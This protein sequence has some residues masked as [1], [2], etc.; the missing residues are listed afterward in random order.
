MNVAPL[1]AF[2]MIV[3]LGVYGGAVQ[4]NSAEAQQFYDRLITPPST[5]AGNLESAYNAL[6]DGSVAAG[7]MARV[8]AMF[9]PCV[10]H[11]GPG[12]TNIPNT[13]LL[14]WA[15]VEYVSGTYSFVPRSGWQG[16]GGWRLNTRWSLSTVAPAVY[17]R[18]DAMLFFWCGQASLAANAW[19]LGL[20]AEDGTA[21]AAVHL[22]PVVTNEIHAQINGATATTAPNTS[23]EGLFLA[24]RTDANTQ[25]IWKDGIKV[26]ESSV[27]S[28]AI[29][30][31]MMML[32]PAVRTR[33]WGWGASLTPAQQVTFHSLLS[34]F[35]TAM[36]GGSFVEVTQLDAGGKTGA[37]FDTGT[38]ALFYTFT[39]LAGVVHGF[40]I[41]TGTETVPAAGATVWHQ[42]QI[43]VGSD[44]DYIAVQSA[45][46]ISAISGFSAVAI[47][48]I[49][50]VTLDSP[51]VVAPASAAT[52]G[53]TLSIVQDGT[54]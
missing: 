40:W 53:L 19:M 15:N 8:D 38:T 50:T 34:A 12:C 35:V 28:V 47:G 46:A 32:T 33:V 11:Q 13:T 42:I 7:I 14:Q 44:G 5:T 36:T 52:S 6:I 9:G 41:N 20:R 54:A 3:P 31:G 26:A 30:A 29:P 24:Q 49:C 39:T 45:I 18:N 22:A 43:V 51:G 1:L 16:S 48:P 4:K 23:T 27:A 2:L 21:A 37:D 25:Q 17:T 10:R